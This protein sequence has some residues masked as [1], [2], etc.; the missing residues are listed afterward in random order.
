MLIIIDKF[1]EHQRSSDETGQNLI[2]IRNV[3][4][5]LNLDLSHMHALM[6]IIICFRGKG[7]E[8]KIAD[9]G[10]LEF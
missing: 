5:C 1:K 4:S 7:L 2:E 9:L 3:Q 6:H 8:D 10:E